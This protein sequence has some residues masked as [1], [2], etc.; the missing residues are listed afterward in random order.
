MTMRTTID[1]A[2]SQTHSQGLGRRGVGTPCHTILPLCRMAA[3]THPPLFPIYASTVLY[4][5]RPSQAIVYNA[6][7][8]PIPT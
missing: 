1:T 7:N 2:P 4:I 6:A 3:P 5:Y 8:F